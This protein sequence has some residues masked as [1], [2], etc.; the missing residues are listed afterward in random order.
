MKIHYIYP[1]ELELDEAI[2]YY[3]YQ[4]PW[5]GTEFYNE[6]KKVLKE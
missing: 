6:V 4:L 3:N 5:L 2:E 1:S